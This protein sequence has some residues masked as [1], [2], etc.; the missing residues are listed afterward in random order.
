MAPLNAAK[1][2]KG[3]LTVRLLPLVELVAEAALTVHWL[4]DKEVAVPRVMGPS[5]VEPESLSRLRK[6]VTQ[7]GRSSLTPNPSPKE[8]GVQ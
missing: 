6:R 1:K 4:F 8:R 5:Q 3:I 2:D 7:R